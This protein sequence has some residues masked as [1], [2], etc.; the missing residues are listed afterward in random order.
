MFAKVN[1]WLKETYYEIVPSY[2]TNI[3]SKRRILKQSLKFAFIVGIFV[4]LFVFLYLK[5]GIWATAIFAFPF[6]LKDI[7][8]LYSYYSKE[9]ELK[10]GKKSI[11]DFSRKYEFSAKQKK[12][13]LALG[14]SKL[15]IIIILSI[16]GLYKMSLP[17]TQVKF[18]SEEDLVLVLQPGDTLYSRYG[19]AD[20]SIREAENTFI[21]VAT[22]RKRIRYNYFYSDAYTDKNKMIG[23]YYRLNFL[24]YQDSLSM[25][26]FAIK[27][28]HPYPLNYTPKYSN[29]S[30]FETVLDDSLLFVEPFQVTISPEHY[31]R[32]VKEGKKWD[33]RWL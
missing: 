30:L 16:L 19:E 15:L 21:K 12:Y 29:D 7:I 11:R 27:P 2:Q 13:S 22:G 8:I 31:S 6:A 33:F 32:L 17:D 20:I 10:F 18:I 23:I 9:V 3:P 4:W 25:K 1:H 28:L 5:K 14:F 24:G 26:F